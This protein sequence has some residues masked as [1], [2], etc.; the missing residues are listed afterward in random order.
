[1]SR[2][3]KRTLSQRFWEKV[4][5]K[6]EDDCWI[7]KA[8]MSRNYGSFGI[9]TS[10][11]VRAHRVAWTLTYGLIPKGKCVLHHCDNPSCVNPKHLFIGTQADNVYDMYKK[12]RAANNRGEDHPQRK[13]SEKQI[14]EIR[15][16]Y[17]PRKYSTIKLGKEY[18]VHTATIQD[19]I[20][21]RSWKHLL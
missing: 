4:D 5:I 18:G 13:L 11:C 1:M 7:W 17:N 15:N 20:S 21:G 16:K 2:W 14:V 10:R 19:I 3:P 6:G 9:T 8:S 12:E